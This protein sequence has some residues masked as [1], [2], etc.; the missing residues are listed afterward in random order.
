MNLITPYWSTNNETIATCGAF[1]RYFLL[2]INYLFPE[3]L[4]FGLFFPFIAVSFKFLGTK[5]LNSSFLTLRQLLLL[6]KSKSLKPKRFAKVALINVWVFC[7]TFMARL[8]TLFDSNKE[9]NIEV[10]CQTEQRLHLFAMLVCYR[11]YRV[12]N[13]A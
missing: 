3:W 13:H 1:M 5:L 11:I 12:K 7:N 8:W 4:L 10:Y 9:S 6:T 2:S